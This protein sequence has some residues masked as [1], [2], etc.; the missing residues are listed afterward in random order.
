SLNL[1]NPIN[2][3]DDWERS[4]L[5]KFDKGLTEETTFTNYNGEEQLRLMRPF[6]TQEPCLKCHAAQG[7]KVGDVRGATSISIPLAPYYEIAHK[8][9]RAIIIT[10]MIILLIGILAIFFGATKIRRYIRL[11]M[12]MEEDAQRQYEF[13]QTIINSLAHPLVV[14]NTDSYEIVMANKAAKISGTPG[15]KTCY[16]LGHNGSVPCKEPNHTCPLAMVK[17]SKQ[18]ATVEH[19]HFGRDL[20]PVEVEVQCFP[21]IDEHGEVKQVIEYSYDISERK[22]AEKENLMLLSQLQH[23]QKLEAIGTIAGGIAHDFNNILSGIIGYAELAKLSLPKESKAWNNVQEISKA[24]QRASELVKQILSFARKT[25]QKTTPQPVHVIV[26]EVINLLK[27]S[28]PKNIQ[29]ITD[30][31]EDSGSALLDQTQVHQITMNL[32]TNAFHAMEKSGGTLTVRLHSVELNDMEQPAKDRLPSGPY[33]L[34]EVSDTGHGMDEETIK[35]IFEPFFT[36]KELGKGTGMGL[37]MVQG[38]VQT[39]NGLIT[40]NST[41]G[42]GS[43]FRVYLPKQQAAV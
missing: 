35:N 9:V 20:R 33:L 18:M 38:I 7:Y 12:A 28:L 3:P 21:I 31:A 40:V 27:I 26:S 42:E 41:P 23:A 14:V 36:T 37:S 10:H 6:I 34:L 43:T 11:H 24:G 4:A 19:L 2:K 25:T 30:V 13:T 15:A 22:R 29:V 16:E 32:C 1:L 5:E 8:T 17:K 39:A